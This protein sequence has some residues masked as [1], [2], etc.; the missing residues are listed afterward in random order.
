MAIGEQ[1]QR[2]VPVPVSPHPLRSLDEPMDFL[3]R[4]ILTWT[5]VDVLWLALEATFGENDVWR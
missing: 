4:K 1:D 5:N 3:L 2:R